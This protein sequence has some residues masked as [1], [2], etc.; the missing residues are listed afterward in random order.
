MSCTK[1]VGSEVRLRYEDN[2]SLTAVMLSDLECLV[3]DL[4]FKKLYFLFTLVLINS[5]FR[6]ELVVL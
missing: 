6:M 5:L 1:W 2:M 4:S 3:D